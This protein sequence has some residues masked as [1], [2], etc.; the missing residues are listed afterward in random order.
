MLRDLRYGLLILIKNKGFALVAVLT[1]ALG[2]GINVA[3]FSFLNEILFDDLPFPEPD[4][5]VRIHRTSTH[6]QSWPHSQGNFYD[7]RD[8]NDVFESM[9][10]IR[11]QD[12]SLVEPDEGATQLRCLAV[13]YG[14]FRALRI[15]PLLGRV[16]NEE[17]FAA[18]D[19][20][21]IGDVIVLSHRFWMEHFGGE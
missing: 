6:S 21:D 16:P 11:N 13:T 7:F 15:Q 20:P 2:V 12:S 10:A 1:V 8:R 14:F 4:R 5:L 3:M 17:E 19:V 9:A 18:P